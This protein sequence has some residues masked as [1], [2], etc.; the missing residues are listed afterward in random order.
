MKN[1]LILLSFCFTVVTGICQPPTTTIFNNTNC[2]MTVTMV[3]GF[4]AG[5]DRSCSFNVCAPAMM[6][7]PAIPC[8]I[9]CHE[10]GYAIVCPGCPPC[11][12]PDDCYTVSWNSCNGYPQIATG[13]ISAPCP[14]F[15]QGPISVDA[16][17][18]NQLNIN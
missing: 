3:C 2:P 12:A 11:G 5:C 1:V 4:D 18:P 15:C 6:P 7:T 10:W 17:T 9:D 8:A 14:T 13:T 16:S